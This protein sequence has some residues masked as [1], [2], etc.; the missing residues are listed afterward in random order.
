LFFQG[1]ILGLSDSAA[2][3]KIQNHPFKRQ[4]TT[5]NRLR[6]G[7]Y[8]IIFI[9]KFWLFLGLD[10]TFLIGAALRR[11]KFPEARKKRAE[12]RVEFSD[13]FPHT[14]PKR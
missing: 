7:K 11:Q 12:F 4:I 5:L 3:P 6:L 2:T 10:N 14:G 1:D 8:K 13:T 9:D